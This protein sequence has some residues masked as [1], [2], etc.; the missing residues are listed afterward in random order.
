MVRTRQAGPVT[1]IIIGVIFII[2]RPWFKQFSACLQVMDLPKYQKQAVADHP[3]HTMATHCRYYRMPMDSIEVTK[4]TKLMYLMDHCQ[5][6][7]ARGM[8][9]ND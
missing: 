5:I 4:I 8:S 1:T 6:N 7:E 2:E 3:K 9:L